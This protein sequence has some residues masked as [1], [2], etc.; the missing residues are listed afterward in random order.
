M[1]RHTS[2]LNFL[3]S[4]GAR[5]ELVLDKDKMMSKKRDEQIGRMVEEM[6]NRNQERRKSI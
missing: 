2:L 4:K 3:A 1:D 6:K 5:E